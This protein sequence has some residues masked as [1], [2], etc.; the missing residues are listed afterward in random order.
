MPQN[1]AGQNKGRRL[2]G[3]VHMQRA[4]NAFSI[5]DEDPENEVLEAGE[6][7]DKFGNEEVRSEDDEDIDSD[8]AFEEGDEEIFETFKFAGSSSKS[9]KVFNMAVDHVNRR[10][11]RKPP[12]HKDSDEGQVE[13]KEDEEEYEDDDEGDD[14]QYMNLSDMLSNGQNNSRSLTSISNR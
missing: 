3:A 14:E 11:R 9:G 4:L 1:R 6:S 13:T 8:E 10:K 12:S 7:P 2:V 5:T